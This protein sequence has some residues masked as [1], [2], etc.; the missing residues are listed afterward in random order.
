MVTSPD[1]YPTIPAPSVLVG[2]QTFPTIYQIDSNLRAPYLI[3]AG[4]GIE[5]QMTKNATISVTY[6]NAH[7]VHQLL[8][9]NINA[10]LPGTYN[11]SD[12]S[13][14]VRPLGQVGNIYH[15][16]SNGLFNQNQL[17]A[18]F[19]IRAG[20]KL[21]LFG[22]YT[23]NYAKSN[24]TGV[25]SFP[26]DQY[27][28]AANYGRASFDVRHRVFMGGSLGLPRGFRISPFL[29]ASSGAPFNIMLGQDLNGDSLF[30]DRPAFAATS[31]GP[32]VVVT[33]FGTFNTNPASTQTIIPPNIAT[34]PGQ[35]S[36][37][38]RLAKTFGF[39]KK[40]GSGGS[41]GFG[42]G[43]G[44]GPRGGGL[45]LGGL[46]GGGRPQGLGGMFGGGGNARY[47]LEFSVS[48]RNVFNN[49]NLAPPIG[50]LNSPLFGR[51]NAIVGGFGGGQ[52]ANRSIALQARFSF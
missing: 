23:L 46:S 45:G 6:L 33:P 36:L 43:G 52:G 8:S 30:N 24:T 18:N 48:A 17:I 11:P 32:N 22:F 7:G 15:Y 10:P 38:M 5:R 13:S 16:E 39:G 20:T 35:F 4:V 3:Q 28:V 49:V 40:E 25:N 41:G 31:S 47:N 51:S 37:N 27:D 9:R 44:G 29:V 12:P 14:G 21:S 19:N 50:T 26:V 42:G 34:G 2:S 1:F